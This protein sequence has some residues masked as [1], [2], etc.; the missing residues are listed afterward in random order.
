[1][2]EANKKMDSQQIPIPGAESWLERGSNPRWKSKT[3]IRKTQNKAII[4]SW[5]G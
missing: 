4:N 1:V 5:E 2:L 3:S